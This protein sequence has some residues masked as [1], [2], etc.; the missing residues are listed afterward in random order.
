MNDQS[1]VDKLSRAVHK[2]LEVHDDFVN[3]VAGIRLPEVLNVWI[4]PIGEECLKSMAEFYLLD[5]LCF[6][7]SN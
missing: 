5:I 1:I 7:I 6:V 2:N 4:D 3:K